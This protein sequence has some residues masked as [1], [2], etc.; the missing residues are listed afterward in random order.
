MRPSTSRHYLGNYYVDT[1]QL[2]ENIL[3]V[4]YAKTDAQLP[5]MKVQRVSNGV[6][7]N[8]EDILNGKFDKRIYNLLNDDDKRLV[9]RFA[10][11]VKMS[12][13][14]D[15]DL[16]KAFQRE[17]EILLGEYQSGNDSPLIKSKLKR[18]VVQA[19]Q[20]NLIPRHQAMM[21]LFQLSL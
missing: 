12:L 21:L 18:F 2:K 16:D 11:C 20:E 3:C 17:Y 7:E 10:K 8:V 19:I 14:L 4:R 1:N 15:D 5:Q 9:K 13:D 6:K